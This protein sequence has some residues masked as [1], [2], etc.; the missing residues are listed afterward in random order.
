MD[1]MNE[2]QDLMPAS[3]SLF[4]SIQISNVIE[5]FDFGC[6]KQKK[7]SNTLSVYFDQT[8]FKSIAVII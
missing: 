3:E 7:N 5:F 4:S 6:P 1:M 2:C 8:R